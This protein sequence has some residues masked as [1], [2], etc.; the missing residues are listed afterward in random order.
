MTNDGLACVSL[1]EQ[2]LGLAYAMEPLV[3]EQL[4]AGTLQR[5]LEPYASTVPGFFLYFPKASRNDPKIRAFIET[6]RRT[7]SSRSTP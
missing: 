6:A 3:L 2:G 7:L 1:A 5:V 4:R